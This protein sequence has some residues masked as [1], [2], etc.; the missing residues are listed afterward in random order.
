MSVLIPLA[1]IFAI[2]FIIDRVFRFIENKGSK[3]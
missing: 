3:K 2:V 1:V